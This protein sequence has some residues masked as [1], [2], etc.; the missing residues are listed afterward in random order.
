MPKE[1][2]SISTLDLKEGYRGDRRKSLAPKTEGADSEQILNG[3]NLGGGVSFEGEEELLLAHSP[4]VVG[5]FDEFGAAG[6]QFYEDALR[7]RIQ[8]VFDQLFHHRGR[9]LDYLSG[10]DLIHQ[11]LWKYLNLAFHC[12]QF[13]M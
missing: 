6:P 12:S 11:I 8:G 7:S 5:D 10:G 9:A 2:L 1:A 13:W 4:T 3:G